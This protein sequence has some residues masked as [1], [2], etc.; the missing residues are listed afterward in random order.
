V[1]QL[2]KEIEDINRLMLEVAQEA[3]N[4][5]GWNRRGP[6]RATGQQRQ[7]G[8]GASGQLQFQVWDPGGSQ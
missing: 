5:E 2:D 3:V 1:D 7:K 8:R 6:T 4:R